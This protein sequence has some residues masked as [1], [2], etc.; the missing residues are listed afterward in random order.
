MS[1]DKRIQARAKLVDVLQLVMALKD[2]YNDISGKHNAGL[3]VYKRCVQLHSNLKASLE[4][5]R[6]VAGVPQPQGTSQ[7]EEDPQGELFVASRGREGKP[8][9]RTRK[10]PSQH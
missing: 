2:A 5:D 4:A 8:P 7:K 3:D 6:S 9:T 1:N 10:T